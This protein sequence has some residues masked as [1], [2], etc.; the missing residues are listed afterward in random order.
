M[1]VKLT[2]LTHK[3]GDTTAHGGRELYRLQFSLQAA[4]PETFGYTLL[5]SPSVCN[6]PILHLKILSDSKV[7]QPKRRGIS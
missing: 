5:R 6:N 7:L 4:S 2:I 3:T 1:A